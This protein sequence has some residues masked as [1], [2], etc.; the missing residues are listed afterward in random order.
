MNEFY[1]KLPEF[2]PMI[3]LPDDMNLVTERG[4]KQV[5]RSMLQEL[6]RGGYPGK[7][8]KQL[9]DIFLTPF[10]KRLPLLQLVSQSCGHIA[11]SS[12]LFSNETSSLVLRKLTLNAKSPRT[13]TTRTAT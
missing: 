12:L 8:C 5:V 2:D 11:T 1:V 6:Q 9:P 13:P 3:L 7:A 10:R 4:V